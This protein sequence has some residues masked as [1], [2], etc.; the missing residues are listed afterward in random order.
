VA[1]A[2][3]GT[4]RLPLSALLSQVLVAFT[5]ELDNEFERQVPHRTS[6]HGRTPGG[7]RSPWLV[8]M[9]MWYTCMRFVGDDG[10]TVGE[11]AESARTG[12]NLPGM[13]RWGYIV[14]EPDPAGERPRPPRS[15]WVIRATPAGRKAREVWRPLPG[16]IEARWRERFGD[17]KVQALRESLQVVAAH[18]DPG[19]PDCLPI[20]GYGLFSGP[21]GDGRPPPRATT[22]APPATTPAPPATTPAPPATTPAPRGA[23]PAPD[24]APPAD[25]AVL[26]SRVLLA[27]AME[28]EQGSP[29]SLAI[30]ANVLRVLDENGVRA[31]DLPVVSG[32]SKEGISMAMGIL[33]KQGLAISGP[34]PDGA[35]RWRVA[36]LTPQGR[37]AQKE[38]RL[39]LGEVESRWQERFG[40]EA[41]GK[42]R[43]A[44]ERL[45]RDR[46][47]LAAALE[48]PAGGWRASVR[49]PVT[50]PHYPMVLHRG[51]FPDGS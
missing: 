33:T 15:G 20:L 30:C 5:I 37:S 21:P 18:L 16:M 35:A 32:V 40:G 43:E 12:T 28:F 9:A 1:G 34:D 3:S 4:G 7:A 38:Y 29:L 31:R 23:M 48:P 2:A 6:G 39:R 50:L 19:L 10:I 11:L 42:L 17:D 22:P 51:G 27:F 49:P 36:R 8:S 47:S 25:L 45:V 46:A 41:V 14:V 44:L 13:Q 24:P 26:L